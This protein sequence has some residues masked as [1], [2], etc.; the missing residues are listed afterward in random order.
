MRADRL[1]SIVML[2]QTRGRMTAQALASELEVSVRTIYRDVDAL[3]IAGVPVYTDRG[4]GGGVAL[5][6]NYRTTLTGLTRDE[7]RA[8]FMLRIPSPLSDLG[9]EQELAAALRKLAAAL[10]AS[11][12]GDDQRVRQRVHLDPT[13]WSAAH[14]PL[15]HLETIYQAVWNDRILIIRYQLPFQAQADWLVSPYGLVAKAREWYLIGARESGAPCESGR[16]DQIRV[17]PVYRVLSAS[18]SEETFPRPEAFD[19]PRFWEAWCRDHE[20]NRSSYRVT[21]RVGPSLLPFGAQVFGDPAGGCQMSDGDGTRPGWTTLQ[22]QYESL[23][24]AR[25][26][27]LGLGGAVEVLAPLALRSSVQDYAQQI[28]TRYGT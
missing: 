5:L 13:G 21:L 1:V 20:A 2:L 18:L 19:L 16:W 4:P 14:Q 9:L 27:V 7:V 28:L 26:H 10:P 22:V 8:L 6:D 11:H 23:D 17:L 24:E 3:S 12:R 25:R 15:P